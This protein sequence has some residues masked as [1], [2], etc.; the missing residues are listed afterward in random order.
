MPGSIPDGQDD[1]HPINLSTRH[2]DVNNVHFRYLV[3]F[4]YDYDELSDVMPLQ[5][6]LSVL[7][8]SKM[9][10][11]PTGIKYIKLARQYSLDDWAAPAFQALIKEPLH[12]LTLEDA[13][14]MGIV[15][16]YK[17]VELKMKIMDHRIG[18]AFY[19]AEITHSFGCRDEVY[20][21]KLWN[22]F[23]GGA[24]ESSCFIQRTTR[25]REP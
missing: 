6:Y 19:P 5:F 22:S 20:C 12:K 21:S 13:E 10:R 15:T 8:L 7:H 18:L 3:T 23:G 1:D 17:L 9:W 16:Y 14:H 2:I 24:S 11:I 25:R 4:L